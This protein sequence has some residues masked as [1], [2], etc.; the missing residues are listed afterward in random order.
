MD[1][2]IMTP[3]KGKRL[4]IGRR[5][6]K[7]GDEIPPALAKKFPDDVLEEWKEPLEESS[8]DEEE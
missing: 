6:F 8:E 4:G 3:A 2:K 1:E 7:H 5:E